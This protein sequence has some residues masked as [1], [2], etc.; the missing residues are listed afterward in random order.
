V[1][2]GRP[3]NRQLPSLL[4]WVQIRCLTKKK[5]WTPPQGRMMRQA[6]RFHVVRGVTVVLLLGLLG[7]AGREGFGRLKAQQL[8]DRLL[9]STTADAPTVINEMGPYR[10]WADPLLREAS[11]QAEMDN[12]RRKHLHA[13]LA[14]LPVDANQSDFLKERLL[15]GDPDEVR[16]IR[17]A[18][19]DHQQNRTDGFWELL[20]HPANDPDQRFR[21]AC[22]LAAFAPND[23]RWDKVRDD[24]A[25]K[26]AAQKPGASRSPT[27]RS[28]V[29]PIAR[30]WAVTV[31]PENSADE[32][33]AHPVRANQVMIGCSRPKT[34]Q[35][36]L[37]QT[38]E[39]PGPTFR[40]WNN[41]GTGPRR[42]GWRWLAGGYAISR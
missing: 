39:F 3:E 40:D 8:R 23:P 27:R 9:E 7:L 36:S 24:V 2:N 25:G 10:R 1:W 5:N 35:A 29:V 21:A 6:T 19:L 34:N 12:D 16:V 17:Q 38:A 28:G 15:H 32:P 42:N 14:L 26:L 4:Q 30:F 11:A 20:E 33:P 22:A 13:S 18:L 37:F 41:G 31:A